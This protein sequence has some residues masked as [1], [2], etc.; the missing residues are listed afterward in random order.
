MLVEWNFGTV[1][2]F[3]FMNKVFSLSANLIIVL[4]WGEGLG[5]GKPERNVKVTSWCNTLTGVIASSAVMSLV[6]GLGGTKLMT[7]YNVCTMFTCL[8]VHQKNS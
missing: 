1:Q 5:Y 7:C 6:L 4:M 2:I 8:V 3:L